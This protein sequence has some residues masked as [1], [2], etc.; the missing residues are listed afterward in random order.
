MLF[1]FTSGH[2]GFSD[3]LG[4]AYFLIQLSPGRNLKDSYTGQYC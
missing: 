3:M 4:F 2:G 1:D